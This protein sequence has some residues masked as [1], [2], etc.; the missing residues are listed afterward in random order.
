MANKKKIQGT[1]GV[2]I[3]ADG[4]FPTHELPLKYLAEASLI[5]ACDGA[6]DTLLKHGIMPDAV[7]GD[8][9]SVSDATREI[10]KKRL[11]ED[12]EQE[13][14]DL[15]KAVNF[16]SSR[17]FKSIV[18]LGA[19]GKR[20]DHTIGNLALM[21]TYGETL[22]IVTIT[23]YGIYMP[24][25]KSTILDTKP[26]QQISIFCNNPQAFV[27]S[28]GLKYSLDELQLKNWWMGTLNEAVETEVEIAFS[29]GQVLVGLMY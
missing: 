2:V 9:D 20:E 26:G 5:V 4:L 15:T 25:Q 29:E 12:K 6:S 27:S 11:H 8:L 1:G 16:A 17:G 22:N 14:N 18:V 10:V 24:L 13:T 28:K 19:T 23:D 7:V 21:L 3:V